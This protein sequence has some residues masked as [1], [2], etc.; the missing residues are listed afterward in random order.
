MGWDSWQ[1]GCVGMDVSGSGL[2]LSWAG[3]SVLFMLHSKNSPEM[4]VPLFLSG[5]K[6]NVFRENARYTWSCW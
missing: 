5:I 4:Q 1:R 3:V 6:K 2:L